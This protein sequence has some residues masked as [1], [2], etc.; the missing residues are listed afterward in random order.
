MSHTK[1]LNIGLISILPSPRAKSLPDQLKMS[2]NDSLVV[3]TTLITVDLHCY[4]LLRLHFNT[5]WKHNQLLKLDLI[6]IFWGIVYIFSIHPYNVRM[7]LHF[8]NHRSFSCTLLIKTKIVIQ[9]KTHTHTR[10]CKNLIYSSL[11][12]RQSKPYESLPLRRSSPQYSTSSPWIS[13]TR[14]WM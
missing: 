1:M 3:Y 6:G 13:Q 14:H 2:L 12:S 5:K 9:N 7:P 4:L 8:Y 11:N 10:P